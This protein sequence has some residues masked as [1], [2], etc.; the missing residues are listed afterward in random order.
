[1]ASLPQTFDVSNKTVAVTGCS[2]G[3]GGEVRTR[4]LT[5]HKQCVAPYVL[6]RTAAAHAPQHAQRTQRHLP[7]DCNANEAHSFVSSL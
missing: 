1:M 6:A 3:I 4:C 2:R 5:A 7:V